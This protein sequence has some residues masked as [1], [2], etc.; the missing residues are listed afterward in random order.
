[1]YFMGAPAD[2]KNGTETFAVGYAPRRWQPA[3]GLRACDVNAV[4]GV[5]FET[6]HKHPLL[7]LLSSSHSQYE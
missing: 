5:L 1:M 7:F 4:S 6:G 3:I 2:T